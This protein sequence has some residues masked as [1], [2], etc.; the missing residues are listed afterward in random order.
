MTKR[1]QITANE[2]GQTL[3]ASACTTAK[4][5][6]EDKK[7][8][9]TVGFRGDSNAV[10]L[11][12]LILR[13]YAITSGVHFSHLSLEMR[14]AI[15]DQMHNSFYRWLSQQLGFSQSQVDSIR[16]LLA[17]RYCAYESAEKSLIADRPIEA[18][19][20]LC[21]ALKDVLSPELSAENIFTTL[22]LFSEF[23]E[24]TLAYGKVVKKML[25]D[26]KIVAA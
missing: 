4:L 26:T 5:G 17:Q 24:M 19:D 7:H 20:I 18:S 14:S 25:R 10:L 13:L 2:L 21:N 1:S 3:F 15:L 22:P 23:F 9:E 11:E 12:L 8:L 6:A 16:A